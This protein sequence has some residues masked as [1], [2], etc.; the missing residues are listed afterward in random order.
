MS[1]PRLELYKRLLL[2]WN[3]KVNLIGPDAREH[4]DDHIEEALEA[5]QLLRP[6]G[7]ALDFG[8]GV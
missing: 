6:Q 3:E 1:E 8:S 7:E 2:T 4:L 5:A